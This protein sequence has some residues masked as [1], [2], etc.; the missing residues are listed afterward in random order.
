[1]FYRKPIIDL[2]NARFKLNLYDPYVANKTANGTQMIVF[3]HVDNLKVS[4]I[5]PQ[6]ITK[7]GNWLSTTYGVSVATHQGKVHDYLGMI[8]DFSTKGK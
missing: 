8:F 7:F 2:E 6:E 1:M 3:W 4:H 5:D